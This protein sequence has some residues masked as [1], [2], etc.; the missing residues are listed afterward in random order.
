[1][2]RKAEEFGNGY[3]INTSY[4]GKISTGDY[5]VTIIEVVLA[6]TKSGHPMA[7]IKMDVEDSGSHIFYYLVDNRSNEKNIEWTN[8]R[9]TKFF[10]CFN[11]NRGNFKTNTWLGRKG[12]VHIGKTQE[13]EDGKSWF[14][15][16]YL[17]VKGNEESESEDISA[18]CNWD[19]VIDFE[20]EDKGYSDEIF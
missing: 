10:D 9:L 20:K 12:L 15:I 17:I 8:K 7:K 14:E 11:I 6:K 4:G 19:N 13:R 5:S 2:Y 16:K 3:E 18:T 1:M